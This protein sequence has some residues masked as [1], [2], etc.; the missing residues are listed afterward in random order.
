MSQ[1]LANSQPFH[2]ELREKLSQAADRMLAVLPKHLTPERMIQ[3]T[4]TAVHK[5]E[6]LQ[7]CTPLSIAAS[8]MEASELG[9]EIGKEGYLIRYGNACQ[10]QPGYRGLIKL[11]TN[12]GE[13]K[14]L[15]AYEVFEGDYIHIQLGTEINV[16]H[17]P[18]LIASKRGGF[19]GVYCTGK[20]ANGETFAEWMDKEA[21]DK[22][23]AASKSPN[24]PAWSKFYGEMSRK[25]VIKRKVKT[26]PN[27]NEKL[28]RAIDL[29]DSEYT[30][31]DAD[32]APRPVRTIAE[33]LTA[34]R[35][36]EAG[37]PTG[38]E[39]SEPESAPRASST[40]PDPDSKPKG[41]AKTA[42]PAGMTAEDLAAILQSKRGEV[43]QMA[44]AMPITE[45]ETW[46]K[47]HNMESLSEI[48]KWELDMCEAALTN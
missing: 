36:L 3:L 13:I 45:R 22:I 47:E 21:V 30:V 24:G 4:M 11:A 28:T 32:P 12:S 2:K 18:E 16:D 34:P 26:L 31:T 44:N 33:R 7:S 1:A 14:T 8:L 17:V 6:D 9:L 43:F 38:V 42:K 19:M 10:F 39:A 41:K 29:D 40:A 23:R 15:H 37:E 35:Q 46:L 5:Q 48:S 27:S 25:A 20:L